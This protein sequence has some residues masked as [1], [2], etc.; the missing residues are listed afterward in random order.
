MLTLN[1]YGT[2]SSEYQISLMLLS[3]GRDR[4]LILF[5]GV[6][7]IGTKTAS[8]TPT[9]SDIDRQGS[10]TGIASGGGLVFLVSSRKQAN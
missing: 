4:G 2:L 9:I 3:P 8:N 5:E 7:N 6:K 1:S 10:R